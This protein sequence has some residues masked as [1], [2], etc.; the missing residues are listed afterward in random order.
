MIR[1]LTHCPN[2]QAKI[3]LCPPARLPFSFSCFPLSISR[4]PTAP[5]ADGFNT[6]RSLRSHVTEVS[7]VMT[8]NVSEDDVNAASAASA[9]ADAA[10]DAAA[11]AEMAPQ[12]QAS[13]QPV[14]VSALPQHD[15]SNIQQP[16]PMMAQGNAA[17]AATATQ[18]CT[19][20]HRL[21]TK[22]PFPTD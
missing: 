22:T 11:G 10:A 7:S 1:P 12:G 19:S 6:L 5:L 3:C 17:A 21:P 20:S 16:A 13:P 18:V 9:A 15:Y 14:Q 2:S 8:A 4:I